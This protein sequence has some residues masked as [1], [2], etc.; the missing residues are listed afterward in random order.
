MPPPKADELVVHAVKEQ[1]AGLD[2]CIT[3]PPPWR[4]LHTAACHHLVF[5]CF[6]LIATRLHALITPAG[7]SMVRG[8]SLNRLSFRADLLQSRRCSW[9]SSTTW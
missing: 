6:A 2:F 5:I 9:A 4:T 8:L 7:G 1:F 3:S